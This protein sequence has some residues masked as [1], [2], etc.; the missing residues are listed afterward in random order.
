ME[1]EEEEE[2]PCVANEASAGLASTRR[3]T[4]V[5]QV[6]VANPRSSIINLALIAEIYFALSREASPDF[7]SRRDPAIR[8]I[9]CSER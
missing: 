4:R 6:S 7:L 3:G 9:S 1:L 5:A 2:T 8:R